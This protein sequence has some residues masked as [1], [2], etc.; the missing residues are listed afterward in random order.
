MSFEPKPGQSCSDVRDEAKVDR[1]SGRYAESLQKHEWYF[2]H[3][4]NEMGMG[5]VRLSF[6]LGDWLELA[7]DYQ[8]A[9]VAFVSLRD[10]TEKRCRESRGEFNAFHELSALNDY[11]NSNERTIAMFLD[12][13]KLDKNAASRIYHVAEPY[14]VASGLYKECGPFLRMER[15]IE[16]GI[17]ALRIGLNLE[18]SYVGPE[19]SPPPLAEQ[20]F[21]EGTTRLVA[22]LALNGRMSEAQTAMD[23]SIAELDSVDFREELTACDR[24]LKG[25][26]FRRRFG[27]HF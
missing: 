13:A 24:R 9:M 25:S 22:L 5:G 12:I 18:Q 1:H 19:Y 6:A 27:S 11:L 17:S 23:L 4:R 21:R 26:H 7:S 16:I 2:E 3:S 15:T 20:M 14:L 10:R 8:P